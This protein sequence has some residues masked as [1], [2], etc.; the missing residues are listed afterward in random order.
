MGRWAQAGWET[1]VGALEVR[2][3]WHGRVARGGKLWC[4][5]TFPNRFHSSREGVKPPKIFFGTVLHTSEGVKPRELR[6]G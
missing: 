6:K 3:R 5:K 4:S 1:F 2:C